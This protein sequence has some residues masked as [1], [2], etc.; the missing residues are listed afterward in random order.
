[1]IKRIKEKIKLKYIIVVLI[2]GLCILFVLYV[3]NINK[4]AKENLL[5]EISFTNPTQAVIFWKSEDEVMGYI[6]YGEDEKSLDKIEYQT[7]SEKS[8]THAVVID[9]IPINGFYYQINEEPQNPLIF[10]VTYKLEYKE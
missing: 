1:M 3:I 6:R 10:P 7:S 5:I 9:N 8:I 4:Q 2:I